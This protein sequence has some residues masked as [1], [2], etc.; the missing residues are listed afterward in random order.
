MMTK[1]RFQG[2]RIKKW[3]IQH[4]KSLH[5]STKSETMYGHINR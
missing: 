2:P 5:M 4:F 3:S 1:V